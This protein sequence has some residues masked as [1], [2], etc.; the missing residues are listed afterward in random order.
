MVFMCFQT[1]C[2]FNAN[3]DA[4]NVTNADTISENPTNLGGGGFEVYNVPFIGID[5]SE[6]SLL[7][8]LIQH[9]HHTG[10]QNKLSFHH[11]E[12]LPDHNIYLPNI[13]CRH[14]SSQFFV[15][16]RDGLVS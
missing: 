10:V 9:Q 1:L 3:I 12:Y 2:K 5:V 8:L 16:R 6:F 11:Y 7:E 13:P 15:I 4:M 14:Y